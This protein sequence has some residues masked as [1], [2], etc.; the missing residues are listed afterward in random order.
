MA[1]SVDRE[2]AEKR[3]RDLAE[4]EQQINDI[5]HQWK[6]IR[7]HPLT[8]VIIVLLII[9]FICFGIYNDWNSK[10]M[11]VTAFKYGVV[12][13]ITNLVQYIYNRLLNAKY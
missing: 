7:V 8:Y 12:A 13:I 10:V 9:F 2:L 11:I 1:S 5:C 6:I 3:K 4:K